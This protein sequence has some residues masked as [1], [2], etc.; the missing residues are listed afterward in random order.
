MTYGI[1]AGPTGREALRWWA[2]MARDPLATYIGLQRV[3]GDAVRVP[4]RRNR[5]ILLLSRPEHAEHVLV[6]R[7]RNYVKAVT[8]RPLRAF[9]GSGLLTSEGAVWERHRALVGPVFAQRHLAG[10]APEMVTAAERRAAGWRDV[11][12]VA[13]E[14]RALTLEIVGRVLFGTSLGGSAQRIGDAL[15]A[16][17]HAAIIG[18]LLSGVLP[19]RASGTW[20]RRLPGVAG[21]AD[22]LDAIVADIIAKRRA[23]PPSD[24]GGDLLGLLLT[25][26]DDDGST[27]DDSELRDEVLTLLLAGHETT[28]NALTWTLALLSRFP[29]ARRRLEAEVDDVLADRAACADDVDRLTFTEAVINEA[30]R[31]Y[32]P[33]WTIERDA[34]E[35]DDIA[36]IPVAAGTTVVVPPYL[37]HRHPQFWSDPEGFDPERFLGDTDRPRYAFLPFGG[38]RRICVGASFAMFEAKLVLASIVRTHRLDLLS[39]MPPARAEI[40]LRPRGPVPMRLVP[41]RTQMAD[42]RRKPSG[43]AVI[44]ATCDGSFG[45]AR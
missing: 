33:A 43:S 44:E 10:F 4:F 45:P 32:P 39:A 2:R 3:Y 6:A 28:S 24:G 36:G 37:L 25:A 5:P 20:P 31:L 12:D 11:V 16:V 13:E 42:R 7:Q 1:V 18:V 26:R 38:G 22:T 30:M 9:L 35:A 8:Y 29:A 23:E 41:R 27:F 17:Q 34:V 21:P 15:S 40:T 14:M 19:Q